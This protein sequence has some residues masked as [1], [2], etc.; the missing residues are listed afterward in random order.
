MT[1]DP[2]APAG[3]TDEAFTEQ[4]PEHRRITPEEVARLMAEEEGVPVED[5]A[6]EYR[7]QVLEYGP[8]EVSIGGTLY[9][10]WVGNEES[11]GDDY[12]L[13]V[14]FMERLFEREP[15]LRQHFSDAL[16]G[17]LTEEIARREDS[18][19]SRAVVALIEEIEADWRN[20]A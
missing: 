9:T 20:D 5:L 13:L 16:L 2:N 7:E 8:A 6:A 3:N 19:H 18:R 1:T 10:I 4:L 12:D 11:E 17:E 14:R 15:G